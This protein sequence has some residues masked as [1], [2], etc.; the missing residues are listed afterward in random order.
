M[1]DLADLWVASWREAMP[2]IDFAARRAWLCRH[3]PALEAEGALTLCALDAPG[4]LASKHLL[5][6]LVLDPAAGYIDQL[7]VAP[8]AKGKGVA[9]RL[10]AEA[11]QLSPK[12]LRLD[13]N[14][15]NPRAVR[16]YEREDFVTVGE[17]L[18]PQSG[19][20]TL[21]MVWRGPAPD[22]GAPES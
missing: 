13:V 6:F 4:H 3:V 15:D 2:F 19:L 1:A 16:F 17:G 10:L 9:R 5:G 18:T 21:K 12:G 22:A 7:A 20:R 14:I 8:C 11:R